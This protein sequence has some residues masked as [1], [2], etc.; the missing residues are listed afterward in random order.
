MDLRALHYFVVVAEELN[1]T[2]AAGRV[3]ACLEAQRAADG[4]AAGIYQ[5]RSGLYEGRTA[6][7]AAVSAA[8]AGVHPPG[9]HEISVNPAQLIQAKEYRL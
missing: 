6:R 7:H 2:R 5:L 9:G 4:T 3:C 8:G 1:I